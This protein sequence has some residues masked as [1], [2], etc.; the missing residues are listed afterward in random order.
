MCHVAA[1]LPGSLQ[2]WSAAPAPRLFA[3]FVCI[4][5]LA[6]AGRETSI[7]LLAAS[8]QR[9]RRR[10]GR[11][12]LSFYHPNLVRFSGRDPS[13]VSAVM[14]VPPSLFSYQSTH[15]R[16]SYQVTAPDACTTTAWFFRLVAALRGRVANH[17]HAYTRAAA[18]C[19]CQEF[20]GRKFSR[21]RFF[22]SR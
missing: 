7:F 4:D 16:V 1:N 2:R 21:L 19:E 14:Q 15:G 10:S 8:G 11:N 20:G 9:K 12:P 17:C 13:N 6:L 22:C 3:C 18:I 5:R